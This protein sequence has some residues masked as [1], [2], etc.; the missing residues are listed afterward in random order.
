MRSGPHVLLVSLL[1]C[2]VLEVLH[3]LGLGLAATLLDQRKKNAV[4]I[5]S[6]L[7]R[8]AVQ[9][10]AGEEVKLS[11]VRRWN[12]VELFKFMVFE[13]ILCLLLLSFDWIGE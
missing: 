1:G 13:R 10:R 2:Q 7:S 3:S 5:S 9:H 6:H 12:R 11:A 8:V 4:H